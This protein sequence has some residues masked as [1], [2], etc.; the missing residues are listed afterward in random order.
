MGKAKYNDVA[1]VKRREALKRKA[2]RDGDVCWLCGKP[3]DFDLPYLHPMAFSADHVEAIA[4]GG[5]LLGELMPAHRGCNSSR[6]K[7]RTV[8]Q[9]SQPVTTETW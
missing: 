6:G 4:N 5:K 3:F 7:K 2:K 8:E 1:Y 9:I